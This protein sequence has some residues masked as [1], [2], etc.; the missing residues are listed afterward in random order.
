MEKN[1]IEPKWLTV[2]DLKESK[3][4]PA[5]PPIYNIVLQY[6]YKITNPKIK[7]LFQDAKNPW[8]LKLGWD[9]ECNDAFWQMLLKAYTN[10]RKATSQ[11]NDGGITRMKL[12]FKKRP[13]TDF[14]LDGPTS[15]K[16]AWLKNQKN[17]KKK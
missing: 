16:E 5:L 10:N 15:C 8:Y 9:E 1:K 14:L 6:G 17:Q 13:P 2:K 4:D 12:M 7:K 3:I 11:W